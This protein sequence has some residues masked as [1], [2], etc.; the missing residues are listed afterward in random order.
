MHAAVQPPDWALVTA[1]NGDGTR[2]SRFPA[3]VEEPRVGRLAWR[4]LYRLAAIQ[5]AAC[6]VVLLVGWTI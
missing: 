5:T 3:A 2:S 1:C 4:G 6:R